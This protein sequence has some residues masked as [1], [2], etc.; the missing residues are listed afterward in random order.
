M[1]RLLK[2][3]TIYDL[4][5]IAVMAALGIVLKPYIASVVHT[6]VIPGGALAGGLYMLWLVLGLGLTGKYGT[7]TLIGLVQAL[8]MMFTGLIGSHGIMTLVSYTMPGVVM[9]LG[10]FLIRHRVCCPGC[11]FLAGLLANVTGTFAVNFIFFRLPPLYLLLALSAAAL[12]GGLGGLLAWEILKLLRRFGLTASFQKTVIEPDE[13]P[14]AKPPDDPPAA[15]VL[16]PSEAG[17]PGGQTEKREE[18]RP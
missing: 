9:D 5:T 4:I 7:G 14:G 10:M 17:Q 6:S 11:A 13:E 15:G 3:F 18:E 8:V 12:S 1:N 2:K 16:P